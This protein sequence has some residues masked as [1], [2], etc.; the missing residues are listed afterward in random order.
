M[1][2]KYQK[3]VIFFV[4]KMYFIFFSMKFEHLSLDYLYIKF[5]YCNPISVKF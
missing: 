4:Q 1:G 3:L 2:K 5:E